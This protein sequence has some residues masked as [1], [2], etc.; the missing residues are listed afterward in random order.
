MGLNY[1]MRDSVA[2]TPP[3]PTGDDGSVLIESAAVAGF[4][5]FGLTSVEA[6]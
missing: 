3:T 5:R 2:N 4:D 1:T 6:A